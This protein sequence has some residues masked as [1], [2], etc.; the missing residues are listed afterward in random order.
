MSLF[1]LRLPGLVVGWI[2]GFGILVVWFVVWG[3]CWMLMCVSCFY[4]GCLLVVVVCCF[5][6]VL[7]VSGVVGCLL[8]WLFLIVRFCVTFGLDG[9]CS[10]FDG[11]LFDSMLGF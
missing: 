4:L 7:F 9:V 11:F 6:F 8:V 10:L 1:A 5:C 3:D 2:G